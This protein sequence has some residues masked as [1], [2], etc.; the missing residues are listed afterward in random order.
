MSDENIRT[1]YRI[2]SIPTFV[3]IDP[4]GSI[5]KTYQGF[6]PE[7]EKEWEKQINHLLGTT[8]APSL[9]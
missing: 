5:V 4:Q 6:H 8:Q 3:L 7:M 9:Q 1:E 2:R